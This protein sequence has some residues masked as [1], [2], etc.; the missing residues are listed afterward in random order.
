M[1]AQW[2]VIRT[3][4]GQEKKVKVYLE[5]EIDRLKLQPFIMQIVI[6]TEKVFEMR[7]GKKRTRE[8]NFMPGYMLVEAILQPELIQIIRNVPGVID[9][10]GSEK[11]D[12]PIPLREAEVRKILG[13][14]DEMKD[15]G[16]MIETP[17]I[18]GESVKV[19]D[20]PFSGFSGLVEE[21]DND[22]KKLKVVVKIFGRNQPLEMNYLQVERLQ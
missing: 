20:G 21:V 2:F 16:E 9:F 5:S 14:V 1:A 8:R 3:I 19:I 11:G 7:G 10:L 18:I 12:H 6:P 15:M 22:K 13:K 4:S 17:Y